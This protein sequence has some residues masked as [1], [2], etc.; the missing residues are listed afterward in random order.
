MQ[1]LVQAQAK[2]QLASESRASLNDEIK[3]VLESFHINS[4]PLSLENGA[5]TGMFLSL[6]DPHTQ[7]L[8]LK[9]LNQQPTKL[10]TKP[11]K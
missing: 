1:T 9:H 5:R 8:S 6:N 4:S 10:K 3:T 11:L 2:V 7:Y